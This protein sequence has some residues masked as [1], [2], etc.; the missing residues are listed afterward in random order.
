MPRWLL[1]GAAVGLFLVWSNS[2]IAIGYLLGAD[3]AAAR[4]DWIGLTVARFLTAAPACTIYCLG[5]HRR[6]S[7]A[8][9]RAYPVRLFLCAVFA[10]PGYNLALYYGQDHGVPAPIASLT[11]A[12]LPLFVLL[13]AAVFLG[14]SLTRRRV[15]GFLVAVAGMV[16][17]ALAKGERANVYALI[18]FVTALAPLSWSLYSVVSKPLAGRIRPLLWTYLTITIG[19]AFLVP[20]LL[21]SSV[22][23]QW[24]ALDGPGWTALVYLA[25][26][27]TVLGFAVWTWLLEHLPAST[28]GLSVFLNPPLTTLSKVALAA[29]APATFVFAV[30][31][32]ELIGGGLTLLGLLV[33][34]GFGPSVLNRFRA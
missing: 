17:V 29:A 10:V 9:L 33:A 31:K 12:L 24:G 20:L 27:C 11:T 28:V 21:A 32:Q 18:V 15:L 26:P 6:E 8:V 16:V 23:Q 14:E 19:S 25:L 34:V 30:T 2:F 13:L 5:F 1:A 22:R 7:L 4:F 3:R